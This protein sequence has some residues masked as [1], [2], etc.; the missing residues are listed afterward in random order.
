MW[1]THDRTFALESLRMAVVQ[2]LFIYPVKSARAIACQT[3]RLGATGLEWDRQWMA[4]D[5]Q[6]TFVS[7]RTH[8]K[9]AQVVPAI[10]TDSLKLMAPDLDPLRLPLA[11]AGEAVTVKVWKD[12]CTGLDQGDE[13]AEWISRAVGG[14][15]RLVRQAPL[16]DRMADSKFAGR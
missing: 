3:A 2:D 4:V 16:L 6:R 13:A 11:P 12:H 8:P 5:A 1:Q 7:Q 10:E 9:L 15:L 14:A